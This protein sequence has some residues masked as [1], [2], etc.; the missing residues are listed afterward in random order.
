MKVFV[1]P[2]GIVGVVVP[3]TIPAPSIEVRSDV[4][5]ISDGKTTLIKQ[6]ASTGKGRVK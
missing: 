5:G 2:A 1:V 6:F 3:W 4:R